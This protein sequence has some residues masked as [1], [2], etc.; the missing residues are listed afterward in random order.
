[1]ERL[2]QNTMIRRVRLLDILFHSNQWISMGDLAKRLKCSQQTLLSD[3]EYFESE[4]LDYVVMEVS[5]KQGIRVYMNRNH[6]ISELYKK[7]M[8]SSSDL[9]LLESFFFYPNQDTSFHIKR[10]YSSESSLYRSYKR[11]KLALKD[12]KIEINHD[13]DTYVLV[14]ENELQLRLFLIVYF[15]EAYEESEWPFSIDKEYIYK[16]VN[17]TI[18]IFP[19]KVTLNSMK[20]L[21]Y[22]MA[23][24]IIR[25]EQGFILS[26]NHHF[27]KAVVI[28]DTVF[29]TLESVLCLRYPTIKC[30]RFYQSIFWWESIWEDY[31]EKN[32]VKRWSDTFLEKLC[33]SLG[34]KIAEKNKIELTNWIQFIYARYKVYPFQESI[35][36][37]RFT[38]SSIA[39]KRNYPVYAQKVLDILRLL[40][41][42]TSFPWYSNYYD[43]LLHETFFQ[44]NELYQQLDKKYPKVVVFVYSDLGEE[45]EVFLSYL[46]KNKFP[47]RVDVYCARERSS[48]KE[49]GA[50]INYDLCISNYTL[51][52]VEPENFVVVEDI[53]STK[54]L[55]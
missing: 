26:V 14:G 36:H 49:G 21:M 10:L 54:K 55:D 33:S 29:E 22:S 42:Q 39:I 5:K 37:N 17:S 15:C 50:T 20:F 41:K 23:I 18:K 46:M 6:S 25:E 51:K 30:D 27:K 7:M 19:F 48:S 40:E 38:Q 53:P 43:E 32:S 8:K 11:L 2:I 1:M 34:I 28:N 16:L 12:R 44:W 13:Q 52:N 3:C 4:W 35:I 31:E 9:A 45:H 24:S 47:K